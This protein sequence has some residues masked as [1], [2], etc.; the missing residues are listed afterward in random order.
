MTELCSGAALLHLPQCDSN[1]KGAT[2]C[3]D[4]Q[5]IPGGKLCCTVTEM[6][7]VV[8]G[9]GGCN[10]AMALNEQ[11][12]KV[13]RRRPSHLRQLEQF[14]HKSGPHDLSTGAEV[15]LRVTELA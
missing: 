14:S 10:R 12:L 11:P 7:A 2:E 15:S 6:S 3:Q 13:W 1:L 5:G 9:R 8:T 4:Y